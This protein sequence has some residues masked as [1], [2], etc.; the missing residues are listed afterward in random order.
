MNSRDDF[1]GTYDSLT[2]D[3]G[4]QNLPSDLFVQ[5]HPLTISAGGEVGCLLTWSDGGGNQWSLT[6]GWAPQ[7][8]GSLTGIMVELMGAEP[9][10]VEATVVLQAGRSLQGSLLSTMIT[11]GPGTF[12][13]QATVPPEDEPR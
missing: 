7:L 11:G 2:W 12:T 13:G 10:L 9:I 6:L 8:D 5:D 3:P 4:D 1:I